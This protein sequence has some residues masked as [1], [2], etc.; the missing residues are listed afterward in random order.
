M[1]S[2]IR[3]PHILRC[4]G[5]AQIRTIAGLFQQDP[6]ITMVVNLSHASYLA[7]LVSS[8]TVSQYVTRLLYT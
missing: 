6:T 7:W 5:L 8:I 2:D 1:I 3:T 4:F